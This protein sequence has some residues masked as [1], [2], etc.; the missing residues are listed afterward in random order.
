MFQGVANTTQ[1]QK[2]QV[3]ND[4]LVYFISDG[5]YLVLA[6]LLVTLL[7]ALANRRHRLI[8]NRPGKVA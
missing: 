1:D 4:G 2:S 3:L 5:L 7:T 6:D 8:R